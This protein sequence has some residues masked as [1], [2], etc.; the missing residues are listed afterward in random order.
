MNDFVERHAGALQLA[1]V[2]GVVGLALLLS[3]SLRPD[4]SGPS[5]VARS[6]E[7]VVTIVTPAAAPFRPIIELNGVVQARTITRIVPQVSGRVVKVGATFRPGASV[8]KGNVLFVID[9]SDYTLAVER[10]L[11]EIAIARSDLARL[12]AEAAAEREI[13]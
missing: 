13:W 5:S 12:E 2:V 8:A 3:S 6:N 11:A 7:T 10:T 9:P 4:S 1:F